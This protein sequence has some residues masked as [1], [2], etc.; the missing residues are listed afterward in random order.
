MFVRLWMAEN[1]TTIS[2]TTSV[3]KARLLMQDIA[4]RRLPVVNEEN[5]LVGIVSTTDIYNA[6]PSS[7]DGS[8]AGS[9]LVFSESTSVGDIMTPDP[10]WVGA[11]TPLELVAKRMRQHKVGA[12]PVLDNN[13][14]VGIITESDI[15][16]AF[17]EIFA[18]NE[19]GVRVEII[20]GKT[21]DEFYDLLGVLRRY[22]VLILSMSI[23][24]NYGKNQRLITMKIDGE[25]LEYAFN[26]ARKLGVQINYIQDDSEDF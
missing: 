14:L 6:L 23:H 24:H 3:Q 7:I 17:M 20:M 4:V 8:S 12:M 10:M 2:T 15:F 16:R 22:G 19:D 13:E 1:P 18:V 5:Q 21:S 25:D 9:A 11:M 26:A